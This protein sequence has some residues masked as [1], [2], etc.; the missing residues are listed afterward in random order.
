MRIKICGIT[1]AEDARAAS[2]A[3]ADLLGLNFHPASPRYVGEKAVAELLAAVEPPA[4]AVAVAVN[5]TAGEL[6]ELTRP[7]GRAGQ[8]GFAIVQLHGDE[9]PELANQLIGRGLK[10]IKAFRVGGEGFVEPIRQWLAGL[11][12]PAGLLAILLDTGTRDERQG[13]KAEGRRTH[14]R[15]F[16]GT[17]R[18]YNW[19]WIAAARQA[20]LL[21]GLPPILL[22]GG[23]T[24]ANVTEAVRIARP[25][26]VDSASGVEVEASPGVKSLDKVRDFIRN[27]RN[28]GKG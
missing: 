23:L 25:W 21:D 17:G 26:G 9:P 8:R 11:T 19:E 7:A 14:P 10:V 20:G 12:Q 2:R 22:A 13:S 16:G 3:G 27:A 24:P 5:L 28:A 1:R 6:D 4:V 15:Q 18:A